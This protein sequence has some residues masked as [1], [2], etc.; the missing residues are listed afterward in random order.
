MLVCYVV[1]GQVKSVEDSSVMYLL[2]ATFWDCVLDGFCTREI[3]ELLMTLIVAGI[4]PRWT[5]EDYNK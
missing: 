4:F 5:G 1:L 3:I 2:L